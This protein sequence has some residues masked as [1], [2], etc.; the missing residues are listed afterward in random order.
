MI[1]TKDE[2]RIRITAATAYMLFQSYVVPYFPD[3]T[4]EDCPRRIMGPLMQRGAVIAGVIVSEYETS[5][6][7]NGFET[8]DLLSNDGE[9]E[10]DI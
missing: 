9:G 8:M 10:D 4:W 6:K 2:I 1:E 3:L 7:L 5:M